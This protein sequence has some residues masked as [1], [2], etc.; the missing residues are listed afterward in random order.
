MDAHRFTADYANVRPF[1]RRLRRA[2]PAV[3]RVLIQ[4]APGEEPVS[5]KDPQLY[6]YARLLGT[7]ARWGRSAPQPRK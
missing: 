7:R 5:R 6:G 2:S 3:A 1:M 4:T